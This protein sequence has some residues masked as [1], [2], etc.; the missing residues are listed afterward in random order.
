MKRNSLLF[1][2]AILGVLSFS[3][4]KAFTKLRQFW[5]YLKEVQ[6]K[7]REKLQKQ[8]DQA[9]ELQKQVESTTETLKMEQKKEHEAIRAPLKAFAIAVSETKRELAAQIEYM[10][11]MRNESA[12]FKAVLASIR[13]LKNS[14]V[15]QM[16]PTE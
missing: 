9:Y 8:I 1:L 7:R 10:Q 4:G 6:E 3:H 13:Q 5:K 15:Q 14:I 16:L 2:L 12:E 11:F